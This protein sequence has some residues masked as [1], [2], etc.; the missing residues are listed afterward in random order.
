MVVPEIKI[1]FLEVEVEVLV[2]LGVILH[3]LNLEMVEMG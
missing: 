2:N 3:S 1:V